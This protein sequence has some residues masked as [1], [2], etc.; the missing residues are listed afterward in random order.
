MYGE[1]PRDFI[2]SLYKNEAIPEIFTFD[3]GETW[4]GILGRGN[5]TIYFI[6]VPNTCLHL[7]RTLK[8]DDA[9]STRKNAWLKQIFVLYI[10]V[11]KTITELVVTMA[12]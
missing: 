11:N 12:M 7:L 8:R 4:S 6:G 1:R 2:K 9:S 10:Y 5:A 3:F